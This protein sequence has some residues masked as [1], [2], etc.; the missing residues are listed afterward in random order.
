MASKAPPSATSFG[1]NLVG[2]AAALV[3]MYV[4]REQHLSGPAAVGG[5][6]A[7]GVVP[8]V[9]LDLLVLKVHRRASTGLDWDRTAASP[10][11][12]RVGTKLLGLAI[13]VGPIAL[14]YWVMPEY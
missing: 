6:C 3:T 4:L 2:V 9:L 11:F 12:V 13:T 8:I 14:A 10:D 7:A 5:V 1:L